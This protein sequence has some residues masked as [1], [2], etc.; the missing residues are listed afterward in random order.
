MIFSVFSIFLNS[1][2]L[3]LRF[4]QKYSGKENQMNLWSLFKRVTK[5]MKFKYVNKAE[6]EPYPITHAFFRIQV[7]C[8]SN[9]HS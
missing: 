6:R 9:L 1:L 5:A 7:E 4:Q 3:K 8:N 2:R